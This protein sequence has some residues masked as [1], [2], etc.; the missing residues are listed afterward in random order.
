MMIMSSS[1]RRLIVILLFFSCFPR[2]ALSSVEAASHS[3][4]RHFAEQPHLLQYQA[5]DQ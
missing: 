4:S 2:E 5:S 3:F 1:E